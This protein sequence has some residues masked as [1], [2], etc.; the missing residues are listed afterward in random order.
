[1]CGTFNQVDHGQS[2]NYLSV[3]SLFFV[4]F[5]FGH[6]QYFSIFVSL[7]TLLAIYYYKIYLNRKLLW[8]ESIKVEK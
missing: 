1:M 3:R 6:V 8:F 4:F 5:F 2:Y 7:V